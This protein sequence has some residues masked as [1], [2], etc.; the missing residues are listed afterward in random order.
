MRWTA[1]EHGAECSN[2]AIDK[3]QNG[4]APL[5]GPFSH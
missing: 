2:R 1:Q 3:I 5:G 4:S